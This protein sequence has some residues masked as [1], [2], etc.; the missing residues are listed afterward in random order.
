[1][2]TQLTGSVRMAGDIG[3]GVEVRIHLEQETLTLAAVGGSDIG[4]WP[5]E[6]VGIFSKPDG[7]HLRLEGEEVV[8]R[9][10]DDARFAMAIGVSTPTNRLARQMAILRDSAESPAHLVVDLTDSPLPGADTPL[11]PRRSNRMANGLAYLGP[12]VV[13]TATMAVVASIVAIASGSAISFPGGVPAWPAMTLASVILVAGGFAAFQN[14]TNGRG[15]IATGIIVGL[16]TILLSAGR[17]DDVGLAAEALLAFTLATVI[18][19]V[20]LAIDTAG[21]GTGS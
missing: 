2:A 17:L 18:S 10:E 20:L 6:E 15:A 8:L 21:R 13:I 12:L 4:T 5:L 14:P 3:R 16:L 9:T 11:A 7:F 19:G 1:M